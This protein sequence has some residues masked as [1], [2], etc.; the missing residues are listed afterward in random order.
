M[1][2]FTNGRQADAADQ[3]D[4]T[5][6]ST[7]LRDTMLS[8]IHHASLL[9]SPG[10]RQLAEEIDD[11][12][13]LRM[14]ASD[15]RW[16][17]SVHSSQSL[18]ND[19]CHLQFEG[20]TRNDHHN[21]VSELVLDLSREMFFLDLPRLYQVL[22]LGQGDTCSLRLT[23]RID[24]VPIRDFINREIGSTPPQVNWTTCAL[25]LSSTLCWTSRRLFIDNVEATVCLFVP[26][27]VSLSG[28]D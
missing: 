14:K 3:A 27:E 13:W 22:K 23:V 20:K 2:F 9:T 16:K 15:F 11:Q 19:G 28:P 18:Q 8:Q 24:L 7:E 26:A 17:R 5:S 4:E 1:G 25:Q 21:D 12:L 10:A 6:L